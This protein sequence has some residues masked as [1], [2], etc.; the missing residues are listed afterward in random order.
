[1]KSQGLKPSLFARRGGELSLSGP[2]LTGLLRA[3]L[4][5]GKPFRFQARGLSMS[6]LVRDSD[7]ITVSPLSG[8]TPRFGE[9]VAYLSK[10]AGGFIVHRVIGKRGEAYLVSGDSAQKMQDWVAES[11]ILG[12]VARVERNGGAV[13]FGLGPER[14]I[15]AFLRQNQLFWKLAHLLGRIIRPLYG[16]RQRLARVTSS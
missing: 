14:I 8:S 2:A 12:R 4:D 6:P 16:R 7:I 15:I 10:E 13:Y 5:R 11:D 1:L 9:V 3:V